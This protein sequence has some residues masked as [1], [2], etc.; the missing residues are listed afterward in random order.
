MPAPRFSPGRLRALRESRHLSRPAFAARI[1]KTLAAAEKF[2]R[3]E[4][5]PSLETLTVM[6]GVLGYSVGELFTDGD[7]LDDRQEYIQAVCELLPAM[8]DGE[9]EQFAAAIRARRTV[10]K[11]GPARR[12]SV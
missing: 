7:P 4:I 12:V 11:A 9:V 3:G 1:G 10:P 2:E 8:T 6:A 5:T